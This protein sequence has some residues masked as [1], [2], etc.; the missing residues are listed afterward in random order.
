MAPI[1]VQ[2]MNVLAL[3][4]GSDVRPGVFCEVVAERGHALE[5]WSLAWDEP[6]PRPIDDYGAV[7][8][9]GGAMHADQDDHHSWLREENLFIQRLLDQHVPLLG[10]CLGAQLIAKAAHADVGPASE[11]EI[12]WL[13]VKLTEAGTADPLLGS[14]PERFSAL[15]WHY[16]T[17]GLPGGASELARSEVC[18]QGFRLGDLAWGIQFHPEV[19]LEQLLGWIE[20]APE[21]VPG[22]V[23]A[24][25]AETEKRIEEW[26]RLGRLLA[27]AFVEVA[28]GAASVAA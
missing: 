19:T 17:Y 21:E 7:L 4:H 16:Y 3:I 10:V 9:F 14:F 5:E 6:S 11:P 24:F 15:Q 2:D 20:D 25:R 27:G 26:N 18:T 22:S 13:E 28:E 8:V 1:R 23:D 12:G